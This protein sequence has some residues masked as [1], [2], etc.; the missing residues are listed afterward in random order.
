MA[1]NADARPFHKVKRFL[2]GL[3]EKKWKDGN[4]KVRP[5]LSHTQVWSLE[6]LLRI[7]GPNSLIILQCCFSFYM[8][9]TVLQSQKYLVLGFDI[10]RLLE[11]NAISNILWQT[12]ILVYNMVLSVLS[13]LS[14]SIQ[15]LITWEATFPL[16]HLFSF[17][18]SENKDFSN[19]LFI[20]LPSTTWTGIWTYELDLQD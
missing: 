15:I 17:Q 8:T 10:V 11:W 6:R 4:A 12:T 9:D 3:R 2:L 16:L 19:L 5:P 20:I 14:R 18:I 1:S 7:W 13:H